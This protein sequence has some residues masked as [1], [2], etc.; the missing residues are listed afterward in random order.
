MLSLDAPVIAVLWLAALEHTHRLHLPSVFY[1]GLFVATWLVYALDRTADADADSR[2]AKHGLSAR[3]AFHTRHR[4]LLYRLFVPAC[5]AY[6]LWAA[7]WQVPQALVVQGLGLSLLGTLY[8]ACFAARERGPLRSFLLLLAIVIGLVLVATMPL[9]LWR[10]MAFAF[11]L[12][13]AASSVAR[14]RADNRWSLVLPK[15]M[16]AALLF[17]LGTSAGVHFWCDGAHGFLCV[18]TWMLWAVAALNMIGISCAESTHGLPPAHGS[19]LQHYPRLNAYYP[20]AA[21]GIAL[22]AGTVLWQ[23]RAGAHPDG[24]DGMAAMSLLASCLLGL[25][26]HY[27]AQ[28]N[29]STYRTL[30]DLALLLALPLVWWV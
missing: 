19:L 23:A 25:L 28:I 14:G 10:R 30:A 5:A 15:E 20:S 21:L 24:V 2:L 4:F 16:A 12:V 13:L 8:L 1:T 18:E 26:H 29:P 6:L 11:A 9:P 7:L 22:L 27:R 3:H 17:V